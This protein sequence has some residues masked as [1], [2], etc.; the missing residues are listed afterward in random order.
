MAH[1]QDNI[2]EDIPLVCIDLLAQLADKQEEMRSK[3]IPLSRIEDEEWLSSS[4]RLPPDGRQVAALRRLL[5][6]LE[7][8]VTK[9]VE[10]DVAAR[11]V[12]QVQAQQ[13]S[14]VSDSPSTA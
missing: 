4:L 12:C 6:W 3:N 1:T 2:I 10:Y 13:V 14:Q 8:M 7:T 11:K 5:L 9:H